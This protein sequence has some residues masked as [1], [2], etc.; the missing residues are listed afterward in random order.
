[1]LFYLVEYSDLI[2]IFFWGNLFW[3]IY[4]YIR[5]AKIFISYLYCFEQIFSFCKNS[6]LFISEKMFICTLTLFDLWICS[7]EFTCKYEVL[8]Y[9]KIYNLFKLN[10]VVITIQFFC[11]W[12]YF[13][14]CKN[15]T[16]PKSMHVFMKPWYVWQYIFAK[17]ISRNHW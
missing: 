13:L 4:F 15:V 8:I 17:V 9:I 1:M 7:R 6:F 5:I 10:S 14:G 2:L 11:F 16:S 3:K 12:R